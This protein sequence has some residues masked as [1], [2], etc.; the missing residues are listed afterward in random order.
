M[1]KLVIFVYLVLRKC[2]NLMTC[3]ITCPC[4]KSCGFVLHPEMQYCGLRN[5]KNFELNF[6]AFSFKFYNHGVADCENCIGCK[7]QSLTRWSDGHFFRHKMWDWGELMEP[8]DLLSCHLS[9]SSSVKVKHMHYQL[10]VNLV[11]LKNI[12]T[13]GLV[14]IEQI[15]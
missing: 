5:C 12:F 11:K 3:P 7:N 9:I 4:V 6:T 8:W 13:H 15:H 14:N 1:W 10:D 2:Y